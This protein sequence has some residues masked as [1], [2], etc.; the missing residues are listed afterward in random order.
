MNRKVGTNY[1]EG[2]KWSKHLQS[3]LFFLKSQSSQTR[4]LLIRAERKRD[5]AGGSCSEDGCKPGDNEC[6]PL[7]PPLS[8]SRYVSIKSSLN[9]SSEPPAAFTPRLSVLD[10]HTRA[11]AHTSSSCLSKLVTLIFTAIKNPRTMVLSSFVIRLL[12]F[13]IVIPIRKSLIEINVGIKRRSSD[14]LKIQKVK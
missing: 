7:S 10:K 1:F 3:F 13:H 12:C 9:I 4:G 2:C 11:H 5:A 6:G 8:L 14:T